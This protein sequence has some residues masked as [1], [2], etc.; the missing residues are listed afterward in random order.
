MNQNSKINKTTTKQRRRIQTKNGINETDKT[1]RETTRKNKKDP[2]KILSRSSCFLFYKKKSC[3]FW[4][5]AKW[6]RKMSF[7]GR[8]KKKKKKQE[9]GGEMIDDR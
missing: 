5:G 4:W 1:K 2:V 6:R 7:D 8:A 9:E 3:M